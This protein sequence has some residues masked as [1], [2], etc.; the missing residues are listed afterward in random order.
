MS[1]IEK[2]IMKNPLSENYTGDKSDKE[3]ISASLKGDKKSLEQLIKKHQDWIYNIALRMVFYPDDA[4]DLTQEVLIKII[5]KLS[6]FEGRSSFRTWAYRIVVNHILNLKKSSSEKHHAV[7]FSDYWKNINR[8][9][10]YDLPDPNSIPV[11]MNL[12]VE[13]VRLN[14]M[15]GML[16]CLNR[17]QRMVYILGS[18]FGVNDKIGSEIMGIKKENFRQKLSRARKDLHSFMND[19]CGLIG[20]NNPCHCKKKTKALIDSGYVNP[21]RLRFNSNYVYNVK[22]VTE[23]KLLT[24]GSYLDDNCRTLFTTHP[25]QR[26]P[27]FVLSLQKI[28]DSSKF[29]EIFNLK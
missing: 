27:D 6:S 26:S 25:F 23:E 24:L 2:H 4:K 29:R 3:L 5:T 1:N 21:K 13:E 18:I 9:P 11:D 12:I 15:F 28:I 7:N 17:E 22:Q 16:L 19:K 20:K 8:T 10:D 14:C